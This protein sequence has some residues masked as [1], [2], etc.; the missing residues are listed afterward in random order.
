MTPFGL[1]SIVPGQTSPPRP[2]S[3]VVVKRCRRALSAA[4]ISF[5]NS[6]IFAGTK[7]PISHALCGKWP[8]L[9]PI[10]RGG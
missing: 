1:S 2:G 4:G 5:P 6:L 10:G 7:A 9:T 3:K 8:V